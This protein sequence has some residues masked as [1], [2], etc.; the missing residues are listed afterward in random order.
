ML[1]VCIAIVA[2]AGAVA[3]SSALAEFIPPGTKN[4]KIYKNCPTG[5][6]AVEICDYATTSGGAAGGQFTV[7]PVTVPLSKKIAL[8]F[9]YHENEDGSLTVYGPEDGEPLFV[10]PKLRVPGYPVAKVRPEEQNELGWSEELK[11]NYAEA[12]KKPKNMI[13]YEQLELVGTPVLNPVNI[14][15]EEGVGVEV[16][17][18][19]KAENAWLESRGN[20][21]YIGSEAEP[22][23]QHLTSGADT[24]PLTGVTVKGSAGE[25]FIFNEG[26]SIT[27]NSSDLVDNTFSVPAASCTGP[28]AETIAATIDK[29]FGLPAVAGASI[30]ELKGSLHEAAAQFL[31]EKGI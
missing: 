9:G 14:I 27:L 12:I 16:P 22:I 28:D 5:N 18:R 19:I 30:T 7:G 11:A 1:G 29:V 2:A 26:A 23:V 13:A 15:F 25:L 17:L 21:C 4:L 24:S 20:E 10:A 3:A 31:R 6:L 8:Q